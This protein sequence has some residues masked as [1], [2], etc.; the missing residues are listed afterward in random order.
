MTQLDR[1]VLGSK[2]VFVL[3]TS[4]F[5]EAI[6]PAF[7]SRVDIHF[8]TGRPGLSACYRIL[9]EVIEELGR[10]DL[11]EQVATYYLLMLRRHW[12]AMRHVY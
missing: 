5:C 6:D 1:L 10:L 8:Q 9:V 2:N 3:S 4:N 7:L 12:T 11:I